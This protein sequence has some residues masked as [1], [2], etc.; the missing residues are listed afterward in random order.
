MFVAVD[1]S[2]LVFA[3][4][5]NYVLVGVIIIGLSFGIAQVGISQLVVDVGG[6]EA[7]TP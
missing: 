2:F 6:I 7:S 5:W 4:T 3:P 1:M